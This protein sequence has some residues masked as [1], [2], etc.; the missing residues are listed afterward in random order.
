MDKDSTSL[1]QASAGS[2]FLSAEEDY[3]ISLFIGCGA[4]SAI[5]TSQKLG[6]G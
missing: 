5:P 2:I 4:S 6:S 1:L 3:K